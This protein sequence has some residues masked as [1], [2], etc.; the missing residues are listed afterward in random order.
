MSFKS[1]ISMDKC[2]QCCVWIKLKNG[3]HLNKKI[4]KNNFYDLKNVPI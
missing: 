4:N 3:L 1:T 2:M